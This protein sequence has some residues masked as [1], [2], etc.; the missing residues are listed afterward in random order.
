MATVCGDHMAGLGASLFLEEDSR[1]ALGH[2][3]HSHFIAEEAG[4][5]LLPGLPVFELPATISA[6]TKQSLPNSRFS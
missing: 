6:S 3:I 2:G 5:G 4:L 1:A